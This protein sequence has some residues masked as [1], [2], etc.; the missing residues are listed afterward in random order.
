MRFLTHGI[1]RLCGSICWNTGDEPDRLRILTRRCP[2]KAAKF[3]AGLI[4]LLM[5]LTVVAQEVTVT[6]AFLQDNLDR[7]RDETN[8]VGVGATLLVDGKIV[9]AAVSGKRKQGSDIAVTV[10]DKW[11]IGSITKSMTATVIGRLIERGMLSWDSPLPDLLPGIA[12]DF[13]PSW[14]Q[15][16]L[17]HV[18]THTAGLPAN[19]SLLNRLD[20]PDD[21]ETLHTSRRE[22]L[23]EI[24]AK[25][26]ASSPGQVFVYSNVGYTLAGLIAAETAGTTWESLINEELFRPLKLQ[27]AGFGPPLGDQPLDQPWGHRRA[28]FLRSPMDPRN[29]ADNSPMMAPAGCVHIS[30]ADLARFGWEHLQGEAAK[31]TL[32]RKETFQKLHEPAMNQYACGWVNTQSDWADGKTLWHNGSNTMW[33]SLLVLIPSKNATV[34]VVANDFTPGAEPGFF[35]VVEA[36]CSRLPA[37]HTVTFYP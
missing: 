16:T 4:L 37:K 21:F 18:L 3:S 6:S 26:A 19:F 14:N 34:V 28:L 29:R 33:Y 1:R 35:K 8:L 27:S 24:L 36:V 32:L 15:V 9:S 2:A 12:K 17:H 11:H 23:S 31:S 7:L 10:D 5:P 22:A 25:P 13:D 30:M 20:W